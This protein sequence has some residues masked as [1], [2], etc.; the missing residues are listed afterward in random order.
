[1]RNREAGRTEPSE[2]NTVKLAESYGVSRDSFLA[3]H[4]LPADDLNLTLLYDPSTVSPSRLLDARLETG[5]TQTDASV[6]LASTETQSGA[7]T[8]G[9]CPP[10]TL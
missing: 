10:G 5:L 6:E 4:E 1:M 8:A 7:R 9:L 2:E 3:L